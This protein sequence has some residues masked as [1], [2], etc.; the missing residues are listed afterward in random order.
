VV[1]GKIQ[2]KAN[3]SQ[4]KSQKLMSICVLTWL[5]SFREDWIIGGAIIVKKVSLSLGVQARKCLQVFAFGWL[6]QVH[7]GSYWNMVN[8]DK[9]FYNMVNSIGTWLFM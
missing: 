2:P 4:R 7:L 8:H 3:K 6:Q 5:T 1:P 9:S